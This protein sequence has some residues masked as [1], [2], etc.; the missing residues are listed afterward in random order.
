MLIFTHDLRKIEYSE[1]EK[2]MAQNLI[3][4]YY[5]FSINELPKF[6]TQVIHPSLLNAIQCLEISSNEK[7]AMKLVTEKFGNVKFWKQIEKILHTNERNI[8]EL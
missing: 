2:R 3:N 6:G 4:M 8:D 5:E 1:D 7:F